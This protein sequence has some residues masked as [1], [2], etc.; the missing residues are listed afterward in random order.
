MRK[1]G[2]CCFSRRG[3]ARAPRRDSRCPTLSAFPADSAPFRQPERSHRARG[4]GDQSGRSG[5]TPGARRGSRAARPHPAG[6]ALARSAGA[7]R[8]GRQRPRPGARLS[9]FRYFDFL[10]CREPNL[11]P[12]G[13]KKKNNNINNNNK[14]KSLR[15]PLFAG[16]PEQRG[17]H[18]MSHG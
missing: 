2:T 13:E 1:R 8:A 16:H 18:S 4:R 11:Q 15:N 9:V 17:W 12:L 14:K 7:E 10:G 5:W 3:S 6:S